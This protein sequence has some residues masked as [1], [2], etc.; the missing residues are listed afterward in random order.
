MVL[1]IA[2][3]FHKNHVKIFISLTPLPAKRDLWSRQMVAQGNNIV[4]KVY[5]VSTTTNLNEFIK[6]TKSKS[7]L[8]CSC[9]W[10]HYFHGIICLSTGL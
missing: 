1:H 5:A 4:N 8:Y 2:D 6:Q 7:N 10:A 9:E 3:G